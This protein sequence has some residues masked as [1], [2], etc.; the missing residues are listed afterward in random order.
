MDIKTSV[1]GTTEGTEP[2]LSPNEKRK[3]NNDVATFDT[4]NKFCD[5]AVRNR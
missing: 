1:G 5:I 2:M 3:I 4:L